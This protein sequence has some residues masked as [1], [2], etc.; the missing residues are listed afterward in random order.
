MKCSGHSDYGSGDVAKTG[1]K[2]PLLCV[3]GVKRVLNRIWNW[4]T[5]TF[6]WPVEY[7]I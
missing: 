3:F 6:V 1:D 2:L 4:F 5:T 7:S